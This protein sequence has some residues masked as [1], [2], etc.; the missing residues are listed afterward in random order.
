MQNKWRNILQSGRYLPNSCQR[1]RNWGLYNNG[2]IPWHDTSPLTHNGRIY[3]Y[4]ACFYFLRLLFYIYLFYKYFK[5]WEQFRLCMESK[6]LGNFVGIK[7]NFFQFFSVPNSRLYQSMLILLNRFW[8]VSE[9]TTTDMA[10]WSIRIC[11]VVFDQLVKARKMAHSR[12]GWR[13]P[14]ISNF[15][16]RLTIARLM[17][18]NYS[19]NFI[20][21]E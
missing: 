19:C 4:M 11:Q 18:A 1:P 21:N 12:G 8:N 7:C 2:D 16:L 6:Q 3:L 10:D 5:N 17:I 13:V 9:S 20:T 15:L 14:K